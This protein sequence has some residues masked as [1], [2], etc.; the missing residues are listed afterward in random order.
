MGE[1]RERNGIQ[2]KGDNDSIRLVGTTKGP[3]IFSTQHTHTRV[4]RDVLQQ[5]FLSFPLSPACNRTHEKKE[6]IVAMNKTRDF[7]SFFS[8]CSVSCCCVEVV[9]RS[10][11]LC[12]WVGLRRHDS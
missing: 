9:V 4:G 2:G 8:S 3:I 6:K 1:T 10:D 11:P 12:D 7:V 5:F